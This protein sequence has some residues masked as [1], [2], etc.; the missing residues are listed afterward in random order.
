MARRIDARPLAA[1]GILVAVLAGCES[2]PVP[3]VQESG[4][5]FDYQAAWQDD[6]TQPERDS[7]CGTE[8]GA[9]RLDAMRVALAPWLE[10]RE[11]PS[12]E[13]L[14][15]FVADACPST[16]VQSVGP[17]ASGM[18]TPDGSPSPSAS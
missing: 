8:E 1:A 2:E 7:V 3:T 17:D 16:G 12:E 6:V 14:T 11:M 4:P 18:P 13:D 15:V 5:A 9:A 10:G